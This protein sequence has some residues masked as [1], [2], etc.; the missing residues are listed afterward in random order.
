MQPKFTQKNLGSFLSKVTALALVFV[1]MTQVSFSQGDRKAQARQARNPN[2]IV[3]DAMIAA[4]ARPATP[5]T[6]AGVTTQNTG[7][8]LRSNG[9]NRINTPGST[10]RTEA[11]SVISTAGQPTLPNNNGFALITFNFKN[12]NAYAVKITDISSI[13]DLA[14]PTT[15][16][17]FVKTTPVNGSP[18]NISVGN[19]WN[20]FATQNIIASGIGF[21][22]SN[23]VIEPFLTGKSLIVPAGATYGIAIQADQ[24]GVGNLVYST[25]AG[26][27]PTFSSGG[28]DLITGVANVGYA[29]DVAPNTPLNSPRG[30]IG[31]ITFEQCVPT[32]ATAPVI[33]SVPSTTCAGS[34]ITLSV[35]SG[36]LNGAADWKWYTGSCGGTL[37]GTGSSITVSP[38]VTT[39][40][41]ARGEGGCA[42]A[43]GPC[44][45]QTVTVTPCTCLT[46]DVASICEGSIQKLSVTPTGATSTTFLGGPITINP[47]GAATPYPS[48]IVVSG[49]PASGAGVYVANVKINGFGH[50]FPDDVDIVLQSPTGQNVI[51]MSDAGA[52]TFGASGLNFTFTDA[53]AGTVPAV[54]VSGTYKPS[55]FVGGLGVEPDNWP[56]PGPGVVNQPSPTLASFTGANN[57]NGTWKLYV[58]DD[59]AGDAGSIASWSITFDVVPTAVWS[60]S[61]AAPNSMFSNALATTPYVAGTP[62]DAIWV[63]PA[64]TTTYTAT[65]SA[66]PCAGA[67]NVTV[68]VLPRPTIAVTPTSGCGPLTLTATGGTVYSW[69]PAGTLNTATGPTVIAT[70]SANTAYTVTGYGANGCS[71][72]AS[73]TVNGISTAAVIV[74]PPASL[75]LINEGFEGATIPAGWAQQ[76]LSTPIGTVP[77][78]I[79]G[80]ALLAP[81]QNG[82]AN[83]YALG[84]FNNVA[85]NNTISNWLFS[86]TV[87]MQNGDVLTFYTRTVA[88]PAFPDRLEVRLSTN[89]AS[90]NVGATNASVGDYTT[91][92]LTVNPSLTTTG[93]PASWT[94]FTATIT[95]LAGPTSGR[96]GFRY[97]VTSGG[98]SGSNSDNIG[99][100]NVQLTRSLGGICANNTTNISVNITGGVP[101]FTLVYS[102]GTTNTTFNGY[103]SGAPIQVAPAVTTTYTIVSL[104][105]ANGCPGINNTGSAT[106][107]VVA[108]AVIATQPSNAI[109]C[110]GNNATF[111]VGAVPVTGNNYQWQVSTDGGATYSNLTNVAPYSGVGTATLTITGATA[112]L[113]GNRYR[114][115]VTGQCN[116]G[117]LTSNSATLT[118]NVTPTITTQPA[119]VTACVG[120]PASFTVVTTGTGTTYQ[121]QVSTDGGLTWSN[122]A[123][124]TSTFTIAAVTAAQ[125]GF[126]Y[127]VIATNPTCATT[128]TS[129]G[130]ATLTTVALPTVSISSP[131]LLI[132]PGQTTTI[133]AT[134][135]PAAAVN[136]WSW[137]VNGTAIA[138]TTNTQVVNINGLGLYRARVT[139]INGCSNVSNELIIGGEASDR[140]WIY[141]NPNNGVFQVRLYYAG[142][143][144]ERRTVTIFKANGQKVSSKEFVLD[145]LAGP[146]YQMNFD[147][148]R[149]AAG[150]YVVKVD[151]KHSGHTI[152]GLV[153][154]QHD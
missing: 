143:S 149:L 41:F 135:S 99:I 43:A 80:A 53:A 87:T 118:T 136:G 90:T 110:V 69:S 111:T 148:G 140:L 84:N 131:D 62:T 73:A 152:S 24:G 97:F 81:A 91:L 75:S 66:G 29:G 48:N 126:R 132:T 36:T 35:I 122:V 50:T 57:P 86:P 61:P 78:W 109:T 112:G 56:A 79:F 74:A 17:G 38:G 21:G 15:I 67:N 39:T 42:P 16:T 88:A 46:P 34:P 95:G 128:V 27:P 10:N 47:V 3:T 55:N 60:Q 144:I 51:I 133:T 137:T 37:V 119:N 14:G 23:A 129:N 54:M 130:N 28:C 45:Q 30:F 76:N 77:T 22:T 1:L 114:A 72:T 138:G 98:P 4:G 141:P 70:P 94:Q 107:N 68:T 58:V 26:V 146:Y 49:L 120:S 116:A 59:F 9:S 64:A 25:P 33:S 123:G 12:N 108:P 102:N 153:V 2:G 44:G 106:V 104:T 121:W 71:N 52:S 63:K 150:T 105:G 32:A 6:T 142:P 145:N 127:R 19:G 18:G 96:F 134:S 11:S 100:D 8:T 82:T 147:L 113:S 89:G 101:P 83:S 124:G 20:V 115:I 65:I 151:D 7:V 40:Y 93:Y 139:D 103:T 154:I 13:A 92:L 117:P 5:Q 31:S 125:N 85:G